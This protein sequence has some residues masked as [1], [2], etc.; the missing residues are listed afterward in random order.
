MQ[1]DGH[2]FFELYVS[3]L[4]SYV[5]LFRDALGMAIVHDDDDEDDPDFAKLRTPHGTVLLNSM[6]DLPA[7]HP[8][9]GFKATPRRGFGV[10][11]GLVIDD[12]DAAW[13]KAR[14]LPDCAVTEITTQPWGMRDFRVTTKEGYFL[15][16]TT[17]DPEA[18]PG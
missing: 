13:A 12:L 10:E 3:D 18:S 4:A 9:A 17:S 2:V 15:R 11:L 16:V 5:R 7:T 6:D 14:A 8:F 1:T